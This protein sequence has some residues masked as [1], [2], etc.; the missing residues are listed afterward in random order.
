MYHYVLIL[1]FLNILYGIL[2]QSLSD[3]TIE[4]GI[5]IEQIAN[6]ETALINK[7]VAAQ[8]KMIDCSLVTNL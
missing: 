7:L 5:I 3:L 8:G 1:L 4:E 6:L 2:S